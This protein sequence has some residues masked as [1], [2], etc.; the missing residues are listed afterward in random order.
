[1]IDSWDKNWVDDLDY[2][3][4]LKGLSDGLLYKDTVFVDSNFFKNYF[5]NAQRQ[6]EIVEKTKEI[7]LITSLDKRPFLIGNSSEF[8]DSKTP[9]KKKE[10]SMI[11]KIKYK[12]GVQF[13]NWANHLKTY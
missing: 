9:V 2:H 3:M 1:M 10:I 7:T 8:Y 12:T 4:A 6:F 5:I 11:N 13:E